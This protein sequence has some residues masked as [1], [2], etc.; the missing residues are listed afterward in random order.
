MTSDTM[1]PV[2]GLHG[3]V[4]LLN[5]VLRAEVDAWGDPVDAILLRTILL[6]EQE[7]RPYDVTSLASVTA[8]TVPTTARRVSDLIARGMV[9]R[10][11]GRVL[12]SA[13]RCRARR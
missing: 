5:T 9:D 2:P 1:A 11:R 12:A 7:G 13:P 10:R 6:G 4:E 3:L 8:M